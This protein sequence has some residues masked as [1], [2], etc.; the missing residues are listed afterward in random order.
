VARSPSWGLS[1]RSAAPRLGYGWCRW[2][3]RVVFLR[4]VCRVLPVEHLAPLRARRDPR[5]H[6]VPPTGTRLG[7]L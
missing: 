5:R 4:A 2:A 1:V 3:P 6:T 7:G